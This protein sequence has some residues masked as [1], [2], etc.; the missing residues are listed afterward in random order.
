MDTE[1]KMA[2]V[3]AAKKELRKVLKEKLAHV[4]KD[5]VAAQC[6]FTPPGRGCKAELRPKHQ[7]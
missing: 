2:A 7:R 4:D 6:M 1:E 3:R 5:G